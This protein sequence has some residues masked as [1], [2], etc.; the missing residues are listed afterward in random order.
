MWAPYH[1]PSRALHSDSL[2]HAIPVDRVSGALDE[3]LEE[4]YGSVK[5]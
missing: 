2:V 4:Q 3:L 5:A 1:V